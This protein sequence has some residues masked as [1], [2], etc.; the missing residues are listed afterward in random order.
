MEE[1][2]RGSH[3]TTARAR[4]RPRPAWAALASLSLVA[5][6]AVRAPADLPARPCPLPQAGA[7]LALRVG[8]EVIDDAGSVPSATALGRPAWRAERPHRAPT[9]AAARD[10]SGAP[11][12]RLRIAE[13]AVAAEV[14]PFLRA[15]PPW[16][17]G[18]DDIE[19]IADPTEQAAVRFVQDLLGEDRRRMQQTIGAP[20]LLARVPHLDDRSLWT[21]YDERRAEEEAVEQNDVIRSLLRSPLR[22]A[23][24]RLA[25]GDEF[26]DQIDDFKR[27][28]LSLSAPWQ[29]EQSGIDLGRLS[30]R[31]RPSLGADALEVAWVHRGVRV[32]T[33]GARLRASVGVQLSDSVHAGV[34][35]TR[36]YASQ[37]DHLRVE[38]EWQVDRRTH[39]HVSAADRLDFL[40]GLSSWTNV[41]SPFG[42]QGG[43]LFYVEQVF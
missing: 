36:S 10:A 22:K 18:R 35:W 38:L 2:T 26:D 40:H 42:Q 8:V 41:D 23:A 11:A 20:I 14:G 33:S 25:F 16:Q 21:G 39:L 37:N 3:A 5:A 4:W 29:D 6:C 12:V 34:A 28:H 13:P 27:D 1:P 9:S 31:A 7:A 24:V 19:R 43:V 32:G 15:E 30:L 17:L